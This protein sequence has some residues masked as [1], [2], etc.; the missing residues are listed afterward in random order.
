MT[1]EIWLVIIGGFIAGIPTAIGAM[2]AAWTEKKKSERDLEKIERESVIK[3]QQE[4]R[5]EYLKLRRE[6]N[7]DSVKREVDEL[8]KLERA[9]ESLYNARHSDVPAAEKDQLLREFE[10]LRHIGTKHSFK[11]FFDSFL[12][13]IPGNQHHSFAKLTEIIEWQVNRLIEKSAQLEQPETLET[14]AKQPEHR[15]SLLGET[16]AYFS[17]VIRRFRNL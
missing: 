14:P 9:A 6:V 15:E 3:Q 12:D 2:A 5:E 16:R 1:D 4:A 10:S 8:R 11:N 17:S 7:M 13:P